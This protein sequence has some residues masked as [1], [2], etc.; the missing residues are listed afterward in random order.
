MISG[1][2]APDIRGGPSS[3]AA[4]AQDQFE[5]LRFWP[6]PSRP[7]VS[8]SRRCTMP[9]R[10]TAASCGRVV[11]QCVGKRA[12]AVAA[13]RMND[14]AGRLVD[15]EYRL[16]LVH[17]RQAAAPAARTRQRRDPTADAPGHARRRRPC[18]SRRAGAPASS[19]AA[20]VDPGA[21]AAARM[22]GQTVARAPGPAACPRTRPVW[23]A[24]DGRRPLRRGYNSRLRAEQAMMSKLSGY[25][26]A[27]LILMCV[28]L[29]GAAWLPEVKDETANWTAE[30]LYQEAHESLLAANYT[31]A[32]K[33][34]DTLE[35]SFPTAGS[36][37]RRFSKAPTRTIA[38]A[39]RQ[40]GDRGLRSLHPHLSQSSER[41]LRV[42]PEGPRQLPRGSGAA[43]LRGRDAIFPSAIR[44]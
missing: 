33:L 38:R 7:L 43:R 40:R 27:S 21:D 32:I 15:H 9:A 39:R 35:G 36:R 41:R 2:R 22:L 42:L 44:R 28:A 19:H 5:R 3:P 37:S 23:S 24:R 14:Q 18:G 30:R 12:V 6:R 20:G 13:A 1:V 31:R 8:L 11:Q 17:D 10:A 25:S 4:G 34:F 16:V 26:V 29:A